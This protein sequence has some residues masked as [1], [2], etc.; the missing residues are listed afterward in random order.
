MQSLA[1]RVN[2]KHTKYPSNST[3]LGRFASCF[4]P[5]SSLRFVS[6]AIRSDS[7][8]K[9][10]SRYG[11]DGWAAVA[12]NHEARISH[13]SFLDGIL[14]TRC[15]AIHL[16]ANGF[17]DREHAHLINSKYRE[18]LEALLNPFQFFI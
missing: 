3:A 10:V 17:T 13:L 8:V 5:I 11:A 2:T 14:D 9:I 6:R 1:R 16:S 15:D 7:G 18:E 4:R 12:L